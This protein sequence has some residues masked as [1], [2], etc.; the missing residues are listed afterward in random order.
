MKPVLTFGCGDSVYRRKVL[1]YGQFS[2]S[3]QIRGLGTQV[4][5]EGQSGEAK[6]VNV[7]SHGR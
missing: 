7:N 2:R 1:V 4:L 5:L 6:P 3:T